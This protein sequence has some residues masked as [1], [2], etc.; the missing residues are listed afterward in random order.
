MV[1][2]VVGSWPSRG[3]SMNLRV[4]VSQCVFSLVCLVASHFLLRLAS[5]PWRRRIKKKKKTSLSAEQGGPSWAVVIAG[6]ISMSSPPCWGLQGGLH[7]LWGPTDLILIANIELMLFL[8]QG[9]AITQEFLLKWFFVKALLPTPILW[10]SHSLLY[11]LQSGKKK[12]PQK[13]KN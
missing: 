5:C 8:A 12:K 1:E 2:E 7:Q 6:D 11:L 3:G 9:R 10:P 4:D 13:P